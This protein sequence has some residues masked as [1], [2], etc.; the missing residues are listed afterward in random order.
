MQITVE[1]IGMKAFKGSID[2]KAINSG[3]FYSSVRLDE[4]FNK[5]ETN[6]D[7]NWKTGHAVEEWKVGYAELIMRCAHL[8][9]TI[10]KPVV[11]LLEVERVSNGKETTELVMDARPLEAVAV[12]TPPAQPAPLRKAA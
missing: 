10:K 1:I 9:P 3:V 5:S 4:R 12:D 11:M 2:G 7:M 8:K 6:G